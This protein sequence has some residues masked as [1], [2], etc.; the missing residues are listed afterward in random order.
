[1]KQKAKPGQSVAFTAGLSHCPLLDAL[2]LTQLRNGC[3]MALGSGWF[4]TVARRE[5]DGQGNSRKERKCSP[6]RGERDS[7]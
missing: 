5:R 6:R 3:L 7:K 4:S 2:I 1:M